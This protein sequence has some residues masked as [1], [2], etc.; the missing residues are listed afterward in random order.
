MVCVGSLSASSIVLT[1][2]VVKAKKDAP[3]SKWHFVEAVDTDHSTTPGFEEQSFKNT[4]GITTTTNGNPGQL[5][6]IS[7]QGAA[8]RYTK[9]LWSGLSV[10]EAETDAALIPFSTGKIEV[11]KGIHCAEYGNGA[12]GGIVNVIPFTMP[13]N[14]EG[15]SAFNISNTIR[16][17][18]L[19]WTKKTKGFFVQ[20]HLESNSFHGKNSIPKR[21]QDKYPTS[22]SP[23][24]EKQYL[25]NQFGFESHHG[26][27]ALQA[28]V[29]K[30]GSTGSNINLARPYDARS[31]RILQIYVLN[32]ESAPETTQTY[33]KLLKAKIHRQDFSPYLN[34]QDSQGFDNTKARLGAKIKKDSLIFEP[35]VEYHY[36]TL[37]APDTKQK[38]NTQYA[39]AQGIHLNHN[40]TIWK[41]W[42]RIQKANHLRSAYAFSS[43]LLTT[44][45]NTEFSA[46]VGSGF[47]LPDLYVLYDTRC[48]NRNLKNETAYG[49]NLG[50]AQKTTLGTFNL[51]VFKTDY[52][53]QI[54]FQNNKFS[55]LNRSSQKG[56]EFGWKHKI[57]TWGLQLSC[58]YTDSVTLKPRQSLLNIPKFS[59][60]G[61]IF[62]EKDDTSASVGWRYTGH[63]TQ[64][65]FENTNLRINRGSY[66]V[67]FGDF[68]YKFRDRAT[69]SI[70]VENA[71]NRSIESPP[72]Y[73][74]PGLQIQTGVNLT[75]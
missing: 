8:S 20:Q 21:Y 38:K 41:N 32:L 11:I 44:H 71:L 10:N 23:R 4:P 27:A 67:F 12:I 46:H 64:P 59:A 6:T 42:A 68:K 34:S 72:G 70:G 48:G 74:N 66:P 2:I 36:S 7:I 69:W 53:R 65:G 54:A 28:G 17:G 52:R 33:L 45:G 58:M 5:T 37:R 73:R 60:H 18:H 14:Q 43:S 62:Y 16:H 30:L 56:I 1:P 75:W 9:I 24:T 19:W 47:R 25:L 3:Q 57:G 51:L 61:G 50:V 49:G 22:K 35:I 13:N 39:F 29:L 40:S 55:N 63:Q 31:K 15:G 26:K